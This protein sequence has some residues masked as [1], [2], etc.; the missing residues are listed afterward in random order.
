M[1]LLPLASVHAFVLDLAYCHVISRRRVW[2]L[3]RFLGNWCNMKTWGT[4]LRLQHF[5]KCVQKTFPCHRNP[6]H[7][8]P[9]VF[10]HLYSSQCATSA[11][12]DVRHPTLHWLRQQQIEAAGCTEHSILPCTMR[13]QLT[14][15]YLIDK[16]WLWGFFL[17]YLS[18]FLAPFCE[19]P[20]SVS[21]EER[22]RDMGPNGRE[23]RGDTCTQDFGRVMSLRWA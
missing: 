21:A 9:E 17:L 15:R 20:T 13:V 2:Q 23:T 22:M 16:R 5:V 4:W 7:D 6:T 18:K 14:L 3:P 19:R 12:I 1:K 10:V 8:H 11:I